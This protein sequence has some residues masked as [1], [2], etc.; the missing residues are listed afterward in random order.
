MKEYVDNSTDGSWKESLSKEVWDHEHG[1]IVHG[2][3]L[4]GFSDQEKKQSVQLL[5]KH[6]LKASDAV[7]SRIR[8]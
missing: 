3:R 2:W 5:L 6:E 1:L 7:I 8:V 4:I